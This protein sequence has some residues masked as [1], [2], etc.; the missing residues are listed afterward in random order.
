[1]FEVLEHT[2]DIG[3]RARGADAAEMFRNAALG[4][5]SIVL[6]PENAQP[7]LEYPIAAAGEDYE[8]LLVNFLNEVL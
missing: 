1:M 7:K 2:A 5:Q 3:V 6:E 4:L 8:S